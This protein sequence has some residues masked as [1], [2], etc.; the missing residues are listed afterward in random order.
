MD[1]TTFDVKFSHRGTQAL[2]T[3]VIF[4]CAGL[5]LCFPKIAGAEVLRITPAVEIVL[6]PSE[7]P[8][9]LSHYAGRQN[10]PELQVG[11]NNRQ[12][13]G[14][15]KT[16]SLFQ[17]TIPETLPEG[18]E[19]QGVR[20]IV[21]PLKIFNVQAPPTLVGLMTTEPVWDGYGKLIEMDVVEGLQAKLPRPLPVFMANVVEVVETSYE[22][23]LTPW[24][25]LTDIHLTPGTQVSVILWRIDNQGLRGGI[26]YGS[27]NQ[28][29][30]G[31]APVIEI[32]Y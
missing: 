28:D 21:T 19:I 9:R 31:K 8:D 14:D 7:D 25:E 18:R 24:L 26:F 6:S 10:P 12:P 27:A 30:D 11:G 29:S 23:D 17:F 2:H 32:D 4:M 22:F 20:L 1:T 16:M 3:A 13:W 15:G 5:F